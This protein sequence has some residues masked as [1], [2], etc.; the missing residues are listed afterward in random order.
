MIIARSAAS[1]YILTLSP[2]TLIVQEIANN[3]L[4]DY[5]L[6]PT[7]PFIVFV[8][9]GTGYD[10][11]N[12]YKRRKAGYDNLGY[13]NIHGT[14]NSWDTI[15]NISSYFRNRLSFIFLDYD[16]HQE[17]EERKKILS[18]HGIDIIQ[19]VYFFIPDFVTENFTVNQI[20]NSYI[21]W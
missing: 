10:I 18:N 2:R 8:E 20:L 3:V 16:N 12:A 11:L 6:F 14:G 4:L 17:F 15:Q 9:G 1:G 7:E 5:G 19:D 21:K 13:V